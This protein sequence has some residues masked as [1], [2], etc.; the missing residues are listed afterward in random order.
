M[1]K[2]PAQEALQKALQK[3]A[4]RER[5]PVQFSFPFPLSVRLSD[6]P[7]LDPAVV[8]FIEERQAYF[9][10]SQHVSVGTFP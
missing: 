3:L 7:P 1:C 6:L 10:R 8:A 9:E 2:S 5:E 4:L